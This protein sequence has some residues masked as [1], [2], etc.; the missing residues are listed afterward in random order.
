MPTR[1]SRRAGGVLMVLGLSAP[2]LSRAVMAQ[3]SSSEPRLEELERSWVQLDQQLRALDTLL[4]EELQSTPTDAAPTPLLPANLIK[5]NQAP[6]G[7]LNPAE[8]VPAPPLAL[9]TAA[10]L[11]ERGV[12]GLS[13]EQAL[14]IAFASSATL[15]AQR[16]QVA[17][18]L[19]SLQAALG[20]WWPRISAVASGSA[21]QNGTW[22]VAPVG[23][24][25][26]GFGPQFA[27]NG[28]ATPGGGSTAGA[29]Y[30][31]NGGGAYLN[32]SQNQG[33]A[34]L[35]LDYALL[36]FARTPKI[37]A[38]RAQLRNARN[39]YA[40]QLRTLQL[41][42]SEAYY[43]LQQSEQTVR[44]RDAAVR[45]DLLILQDTEDL[46]QAGLVPRL[47]VLRRR[48]IEA[49]DQEELIQALADRAVAR[50]QLAVLLNLP[51]QLT[52]EASDTIALQPR[53]P[54]DLEKTLLAAYRGNPELEAILATRDALAKDSR[55]TAAALLPK[56][57]L[58]ANAG[59][60]ASNTNQFDITVSNGGCCGATVIP[61]SSANG[62]DWSVGLTLRW[63]LF[64]AGTTSGQARSL[65]RQADATAQQYAAQRNDI[66]LRL[67]QAFFNHEASL[68]KLA[69]ARRGLAAALEAF[70]DVRLRYQAGLSSELD[71]S[72][73][74]EKLI[75]ALVSRLNA[76]VGVNISYAQLLRELLPVPRDP[77]APLTP[78]LQLDPATVSA[79]PPAARP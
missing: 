23:N 48:A 19:A 28:L 9:P 78:V 26:L 43:R 75:N 51:P 53:W 77:S 46:K 36:D 67:E 38:A 60:S 3:T 10:Q 16:E 58:F 6:G 13:L 76:T 8:A 61:V 73:T 40:S 54:L 20:T 25:S 59:G 66:R 29:F 30:V 14:A 7:A 56:L 41:K 79:L 15:Q 70:R 4:P 45:N 49:S 33:Q 62:Y 64:D 27:P 2:L 24:G 22:A 21:G 31:P 65:A 18:N 57:S 69:S 37:Q 42:V 39:A 74:Q 71:L 52:P 68:A 44:I 11:Q 35:E 63:L 12:Q 34:G 32:Q 17:A 72:N 55:A 47:D 50:R 1:W 5:A